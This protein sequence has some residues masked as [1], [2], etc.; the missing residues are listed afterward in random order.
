MS[1]RNKLLKFSEIASFDN[2]YENFNVSDPQLIA[3][4]NVPISLNGKWASAHFKNN[5]PVTLELACGRGE[6]TVA[7]S[8]M[9]PAR[10]FIGIDIKG[11]RIWKGAKQ[12]IAQNL[13]NAAFLRTRIECIDAFFAPGEV[14][15]IWITFPDPFPRIGQSNRRL[16]AKI[17]LDLY[18]KILKHRGKIHLKTDNTG[19]FLSTLEVIAD[20]ETCLIHQQI[21]DIDAHSQLMPELSIPTYYERVHR[22]AGARIK[23]VCFSI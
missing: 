9:F 5:K 16:T 12:A 8:E 17:F 2:V 7:L 15:E 1:R 13:T 11:A 21:D 14:D 20:C 3:K 19:I 22:Q 4:G 18:R 10:N 6:Y 23:Y